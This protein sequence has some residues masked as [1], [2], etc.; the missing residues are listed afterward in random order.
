MINMHVSARRRSS[1]AGWLRRQKQ[2]GRRV[3]GPYSR[4]QRSPPPATVRQQQERASVSPSLP[5]QQPRHGQPLQ[6]WRLHS[7]QAQSASELPSS[8]SHRQLSL[9]TG[10]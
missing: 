3:G 4:L 8:G 7:Q 5:Q 6:L 2:A 9:A 10:R 1:R